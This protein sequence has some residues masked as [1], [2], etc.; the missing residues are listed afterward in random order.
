MLNQF[1]KTFHHYLQQYSSLQYV[2]S[3]YRVYMLCTYWT[4]MSAS[5]VVALFS[6]LQIHQQCWG[7]GLLNGIL[8]LKCRVKRLGECAVEGVE[9]EQCGAEHC[10]EWQNASRPVQIYSNSMR[11]ERGMNV[12]V[13]SFVIVPDGEFVFTARQEPGLVTPS[14]PAGDILTFSVDSSVGYTQRNKA[15][16]LNLPVTVTS[17]TISTQQLTPVV[18]SFWMIRIWLQLSHHCHLPVV[19]RQFEVCVHCV[20]VQCEFTEIWWREKDTTQQ[21]F[22]IRHIWRVFTSL[23]CCSF[24]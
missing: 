14:K 11:D 10:I 6:S 16:P 9:V 2:H 3:V 19:V 5:G 17:Q 13:F 4:S 7:P 20:C 23:I 1:N 12:Q 15:S 8:E 21:Q 24:L 22:I 18:K